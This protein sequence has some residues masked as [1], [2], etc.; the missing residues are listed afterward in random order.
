MAQLEFFDADK[1]LEVLST[2]GNSLEAIDHLV[3]SRRD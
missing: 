1:R 3:P 2:K